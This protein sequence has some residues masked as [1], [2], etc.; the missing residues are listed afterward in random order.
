MLK[1]LEKHWSEVLLLVLLF[2][3]LVASAYH[4]ATN[5][6]SQ[7][8]GI[9]FA[10]YYTAAER[11]EKGESLYPESANYM[12]APLVAW[13]L[14]PI[15]HVP[16]GVALKWW[17][18][19]NILAILAGIA[20]YAMAAGISWRR[21][22]PVGLLAIIAFRFWP[23]VCNLGLGQVNCLLLAFLSAILLAD[24]HERLFTVGSLI[25][26]A[27]LIKLWMIGLLIH[28]LVRRAWSAA[29]WCLGVFSALL[30]GNFWMVGWSEWPAFCQKIVSP[31]SSVQDT[32]VS[33]SVLGF[34]RLRFAPNPLLTPFSTNTALY[35]TFLILG[36]LIICFG[37][38]RL[39]FA[40]PAH[41][42]QEA[43][44]RATFAMLSLL[45]LLPLCHME[46]FILALPLL[47]VLLVPSPDTR[48]GPGTVIAAIA[49]YVAF[50]RPVPVSGPSLSEHREGWKSLLVSAPFFVASA[51][52]V[53]SFLEI[54]RLRRN[55]ELSADSLSDRTMSPDFRTAI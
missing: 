26:V 45:L 37:L 15:V 10:V 55:P 51:L 27:A 43:R 16:I 49:I 41:S 22:V 18:A 39:F 2:W 42:P 9:D 54:F 52:W 19:L 11:L 3:M 38:S 36:L 50:T 6:N 25:A 34:A 33:Q 48:V 17:S 44:L 29:A 31:S 8:T 7:I 40:G 35:T 5:P 12:Y 23:T 14:Q 21:V 30:M 32:L 47:W 46:Y 24:R 1:V 13:A 4:G 53:L 20:L 28:L